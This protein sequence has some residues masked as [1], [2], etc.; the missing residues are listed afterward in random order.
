MHCP[1]GP[2]R[3]KSIEKAIALGASSARNFSNSAGREIATC[4]TATSKQIGIHKLDWNQFRLDATRIGQFISF[5]TPNAIT[6]G[7]EETRPITG[8]GPVAQL[9]PQ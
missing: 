5:A 4:L 3:S 1:R 6:C 2:I 8:C 9:S 7:G